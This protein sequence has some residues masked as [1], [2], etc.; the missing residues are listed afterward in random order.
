[1]NQFFQDRYQS[2][3]IFALAFLLCPL[4][5]FASRSAT[6]LLTVGGVLGILTCREKALETAKR[7][8][9]LTVLALIL[10]GGF[11]I[12]WSLDPYPSFNLFIRLSATYI[13]G[14]G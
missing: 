7:P 12:L 6:W 8:L 2:T 4:A 9:A 11:T 3:I 1:M 5:F 14:I 13:L 10:W